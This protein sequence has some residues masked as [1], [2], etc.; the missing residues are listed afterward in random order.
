MKVL[1]IEDD[2]MLAEMYRDGFKLSKHEVISAHGA[3]DALNKLDKTEVDIILLDLILP[4]RSGV[5][6]IHELSSYKD[7]QNIPIIL[8]TDNHPATFKIA[9][10]DLAKYSVRK[11]VFKQK[12]TPTEVVQLAEGIVSESV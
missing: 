3:Q 10:E 4:G 6:V 8:M 12:T 5:E 1:I 9:D 2:K 11:L 7:W